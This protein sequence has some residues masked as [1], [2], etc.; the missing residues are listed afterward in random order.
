MS[1]PSWQEY[2]MK[3]AHEVATRGTCVKRQVGAV[4][5]RD[6]RILTT[7]YNGPPSKT[8]H[9]EEG[10]C[11]RIV[12]NSPSGTD[13]DKCRAIHAEQNAIIQAALHGVSTVDSAIYTTHQPCLTCAKMIINAGIRQIY[14]AQ[15]YPDPLALEMLD[16]AGVSYQQ[17][18]IDTKV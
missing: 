4:I 15:H 12:N 13:L 8:A 5:V 16:E 17:I 9:C 6:N 11:Y 10:K 3:L 1:R 14:Y 7:G 2:F 18:L